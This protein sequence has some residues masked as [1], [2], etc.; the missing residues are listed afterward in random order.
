MRR[1]VT[2][3]LSEGRCGVGGREEM[4]EKACG[5]N[6]DSV[7]EVIGRG[8]CPGSWAWVVSLEEERINA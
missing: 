7:E 5:D 8:V 4:V 3:V 2:S 6:G 1:L